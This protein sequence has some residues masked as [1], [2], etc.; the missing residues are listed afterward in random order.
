MVKK[1]IQ[2]YFS[3]W[4]SIIC[5]TVSHLPSGK[6][7]FYKDILMCLWK[8][9]LATTFVVKII[10]S[11]L[12][13]V[14][15]V[16]PPSIQSG[17]FR[18][19]PAG[20]AGCSWRKLCIEPWREHLGGAWWIWPSPMGSGKLAGYGMGNIWSGILPVGSTQWVRC[21]PCQQGSVKHK[22]NIFTL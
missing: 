13:R 17:P 3:L 15:S 16:N 14:H 20:C 7:S 4:P 8:A 21:C 12:K 9:T 5:L 18:L 2:T 19:S 6:G 11:R 1:E 10:K 22:L